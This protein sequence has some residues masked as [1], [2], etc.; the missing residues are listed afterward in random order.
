MA[1]Q[2]QIR[3]EVNARG[4][5]GRAA[6]SLALMVGFYA[7]SIALVGALLWVP[8]A[9]G[10]HFQAV[11]LQI[12]LA[13]V[14]AAATILWSLVPRRDR[15]EAPGPRL[16]ADTHPR[17]FSL[18]EGVAEMTGEQRPDE[19]YLLTHVNAF[20][21]Q[22]GGLFGW[23]TRRIMGVGL[24]LLQALSL[25]EFRAV[26][27]HEFGHYGG[28]D[29]T[30]APLVYRTR[31]AIGR[32][33]DQLRETHFVG[34]F[35]WYGRLFL[36]LTHAVSRQQEFVADAVAARVAGAATQAAALR[37]VTTAAAAFDLFMEVEVVP[38]LRAGFLPPLTEGF[39]T[40][41]ESGEVAARMAGLLHEA[42]TSGESS[43][44]DTHP[45]LRERLA[46]LG[47]PPA[48]SGPLAE[49]A[50]GLL[51]SPEQAARSLLEWAAGHDAVAALRAIEWEEVG[52]RVVAPAWRAAVAE[53]GRWLAQFTSDQLPASMAELAAAGTELADPREIA[54][55]ADESAMRATYVLGAG[56]ACLLIER[57]WKAAT[58]PG[59]TV[60]VVNG[61]E[62]I[63]PFAVVHD[64]A[65]GLLATEQW[66][67]RCQSL[68]ILGVRL[69]A[70]ESTAA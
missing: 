69:G 24:P 9:Q 48:Q 59:R 67:A 25:D 35:V 21:T 39:R 64:L 16:A 36:K 50:L 44:F 10:T 45:P 54:A 17:L 8:Y 60:H 55:T 7:I 11:P 41:C 46:A 70:T 22:R 40:F 68:E 52:D 58:G 31:A 38:V 6:L 62:A 53:N 29:V 15:F 32:T 26:V 65:A 2:G 20:V 3:H 51:E 12:T 19:V 47:D 27:A 66:S 63:D 56:V 4:L 34:L 30:L 33:V 43:P 5:A 37:R 57:G 13:C 23:G 18:I 42:E 28:G 14:G 1:G 61:A 49:S